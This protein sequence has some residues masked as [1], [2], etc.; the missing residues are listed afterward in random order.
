MSYPR[1]LDL[2]RS[3]SAGGL[4][5]FAEVTVANFPQQRAVHQGQTRDGFYVRV[6]A[7]LD[8][9]GVF[10]ANGVAFRV[11]AVDGPPPLL[12]PPPDS[13]F[14]ITI[15]TFST[16]SRAAFPNTFYKRDGLPPRARARSSLTDRAI[17]CWRSSAPMPRRVRASRSSG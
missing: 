17:S 11:S 9:E 10:P 5:S 2:E 1:S 12:P 14:P 3:H 6:D 7:P 8:P 15:A 4:A 13:R 16:P